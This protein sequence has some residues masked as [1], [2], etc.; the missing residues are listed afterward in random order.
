[1]KKTILFTIIFVITAIGITS[2]YA[3]ST[4]NTG[5]LEVTGSI[6]GPTI[7]ALTSSITSAP[8]CPQANIQHWDK[9]TFF[10]F[11]QIT[12]F[13]GEQPSVINSGGNFLYDIKVL[14][15]PIKVADL[16]QKVVDFLNPLGYGVTEPGDLITIDVFVVEV[17]YSIVCVLLD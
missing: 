4:T 5:D 14:D 15:D 11:V 8:A 16:N 9:I 13:E 12:S 10:G 2:A 6:T 17:D 7:S 3:V 1:M